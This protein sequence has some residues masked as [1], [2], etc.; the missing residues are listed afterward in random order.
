M[1]GR[2][3]AERLRSDLDEIR[4]ELV[5]TI[6]GLPPD[7]L[8]WAPRPEMK[9]FKALL[10]EIGAMEEVTRHMAAYQE[11]RDWGAIWQELDKDNIEA[12]LSALDTIRAKTLVY[13]T[14]CTEEQLETPI[15]LPKE[16]QG[17][18]NAPVVEP[19]ELLRWIVRHEY[20]H[21][22]QIIIYQWQ[23]GHNPHTDA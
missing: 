18:F 5:K 8:N 11:T 19:E 1:P 7:E 14:D 16:W 23:R 15:P 3:H 12:M 10:Q 4:A 21:L 17:Y 20:Y 13:L 6:Q 22:G 2:P 9:T